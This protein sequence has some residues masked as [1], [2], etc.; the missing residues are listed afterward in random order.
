MNTI[1]M[2]S[3]SPTIP[4]TQKKKKVQPLTNRAVNLISVILAVC[5]MYLILFGKIKASLFFAGVAMMLIPFLRIVNGILSKV[6]TF[7]ED[8]IVHS[9]K[10]TEHLQKLEEGYDEVDK[11]VEK[12]DEIIPQLCDTVEDALDVIE[13]YKDE[14]K[15]LK[16]KIKNN[17]NVKMTL[18]E[19]RKI[20]IDYEGKVANFV[21]TE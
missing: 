21:E 4:H 18:V 12:K 15:P 6:S 17:H 20:Q 13:Y 14:A 9:K 19:E 3:G 7:A 10:M 8:S 11:T 2:A 16:L 5:S 1:K